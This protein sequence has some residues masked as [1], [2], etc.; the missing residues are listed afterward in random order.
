MA[1]LGCKNGSTN[2]KKGSRAFHKEMFCLSRLPRC[3]IILKS[4]EQLSVDCRMGG[5]LFSSFLNILKKLSQL[6]QPKKKYLKTDFLKLKTVTVEEALKDFFNHIFRAS[7]TAEQQV[8]RR[9]KL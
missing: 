7:V 5:L 1:V 6:S 2:E 9:K 4:I 8:S 3:L